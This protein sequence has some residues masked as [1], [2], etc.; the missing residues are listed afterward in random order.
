MG[1][2]RENGLLASARSAKR[3]K[4]MSSGGLTIMTDAMLNKLKLVPPPRSGA[5]ARRH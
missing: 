2:Q 5:K 3:L 1:V 4:A